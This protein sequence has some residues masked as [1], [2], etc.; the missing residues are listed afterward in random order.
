MNVR[1]AQQKMMTAADD[2][3]DLLEKAGLTE[4]WHLDQDV[5]SNSVGTYF[6]GRW[7]G[8]TLTSQMKKRTKFLLSCRAYDLTA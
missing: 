1:L 7:G 6:C 8:V 3:N 2:C 4:R 5:T